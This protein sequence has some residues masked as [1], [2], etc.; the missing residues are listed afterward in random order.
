MAV[1]NVQAPV[2]LGTVEPLAEQVIDPLLQVGCRHRR[3]RDAPV[4]LVLDQAL[5]REHAAP[6]AGACG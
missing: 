2:A 1:T 5:G 6:R 4:R 3:H